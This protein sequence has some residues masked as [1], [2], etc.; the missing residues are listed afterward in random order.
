[1]I[2]MIRKLQESRR[3]SIALVALASASFLFAGC[4]Y[5]LTNLHSAAPNNIRT[6]HVEAV[7]DTSAE[8]VPHELL[9][10]EI[11]R[12]IAANGQLKLVPSYEADALLRAHIVRTQTSKA[13]ERKAPIASARRTERDVFVGQQSPPTPGQIRDITVADDYFMKTAW[14]S[15]AQVEVWD[16]TTGKLILQRQY[17]LAGE[18]PTVRGDV[19]TEIHHLRN[20]ESFQH[21]FGNV[22]RGI[23]ER[24]V[25]D[26]LLH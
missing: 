24:I 13:G 6:I 5:Q 9:W 8:P 21:S 12:A 11:Q 3:K 23:A 17:P 1:M 18:M 22:S 25:S 20:E 10:D 16:L 14:T 7:Y 19:P 26:L 15:A 2:I 4:T